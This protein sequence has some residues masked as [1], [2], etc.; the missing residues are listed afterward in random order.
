M[1]SIPELWLPI[2]LAAVLVFIASSIIHMVLPYHRSDFSQMPEE[3]NRMDALRGLAPGN[4]MF[5]HCDHK[6]MSKPENV[7]KFKRG[8]VGTVTIMP[9]GMPNMGK[10]L[11]LWFVYCVLAGVMVAYLTGRTLGPG[12]EYLAVFRVAGTA[13]FLAFAFAHISDYIWKSQPAAV[14]GKQVF[15][16]LIYASLTAGAFGWLWP[17]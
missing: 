13:A 16:G 10:F 12:A 6:E 17:R 8:P 7:E 15:D 1:V 14:I 2:L 9:S 5:P 3:A 4:Y 11:G